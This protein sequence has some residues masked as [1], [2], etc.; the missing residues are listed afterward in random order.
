MGVFIVFKP[1]SPENL[2]AAIEKNFPNDHMSV[3]ENVW[4]VSSIGTAREVSARIGIGSNTVMTGHVG[5]AIVVGV[6]SY[7]GRA[8]SNIWE[9]IKVKTEA[10][11]G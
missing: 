6:D 7:Y 8:P 4:L 9:W 3:A 10:V 11:N 1:S 5:D 2:Q